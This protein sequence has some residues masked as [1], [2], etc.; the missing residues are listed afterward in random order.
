MHPFVLCRMFLKDVA[1]LYVLAYRT[2]CIPYIFRL[3]NGKNAVLIVRGIVKLP[4][5]SHVTYLPIEF[6]VGLVRLSWYILG[7]D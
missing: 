7:N 5:L 4:R 2:Y 3:C 1:I 6:A